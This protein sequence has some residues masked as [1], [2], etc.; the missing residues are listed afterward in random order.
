MNR[1]HVIPVGDY[2]IHY[3]QSDCWCYPTERSEGVIWVHH[4]ADCREARER[5]NN[6]KCSEGW[7]NIGETI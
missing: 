5:I 6:E 3:A 7:I 1:I 4:A 2:R